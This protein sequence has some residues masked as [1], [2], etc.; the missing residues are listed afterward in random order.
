MVPNGSVTI[1]ALCEASC[2]RLPSAHLPLCLHHHRHMVPL[3]RLLGAFLG[4]CHHLYLHLHH[5][6]L[7]PLGH[8]VSCHHLYVVLAFVQLRVQNPVSHPVHA[9]AVAVAGEVEAEVYR[10]HFLFL[11]H[12]SSAAQQIR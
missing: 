10:A 5:C 1:T 9:L 2:F 6:D 3:R 7:C 12:F 11:S 4:P 8:C